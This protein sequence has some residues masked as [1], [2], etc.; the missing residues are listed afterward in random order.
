MARGA[1]IRTA[2]TYALAITGNAGPATDGE[3]APVGTMF[4]SLADV[5]G[6][7]TIHRVL[8]SDRERNR[9]FAAQMA[10]DLLRRHLL[11]A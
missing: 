5:S 10:L 4:V 3:H 7:T 1:R 8:P 11:N 6:V 2:S 9:Q